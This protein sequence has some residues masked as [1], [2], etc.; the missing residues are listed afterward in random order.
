MDSQRFDGKAEK[1]TQK[2]M[3]L[4]ELADYF[5]RLLAPE[6]DYYLLSIIYG[7]GISL[8]S[9]ATPISVQMLIN[10]V[11]HTGLTTPLLPTICARLAAASRESTYRRRTIWVTRSMPVPSAPTGPAVRAAS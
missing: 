10:T 7:V 2:R 6:R 8:L 4:Y 9:L 5:R 1:T 11:A 3:S